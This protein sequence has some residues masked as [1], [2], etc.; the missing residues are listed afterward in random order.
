[1]VSVA[2]PPDALPFDADAAGPLRV[3][4]VMVMIARV[5]MVEVLMLMVIV[6]M[7]LRC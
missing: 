2:F 7:I 3:M 6:M 1:M 4:M 5:M